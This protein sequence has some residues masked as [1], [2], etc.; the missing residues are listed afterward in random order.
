MKKL[1]ALAILSSVGL[2]ATAA[3]AEGLYVGADAQLQQ[4]QVKSDGAKKKT[5]L[6]SL[7]G[8]VGYE[9]NEYFAV[10]GRAG[11]GLKNGKYSLPNN[12]DMKV[13]EKYNLG[14]YALASYPVT[15]T[16]S[17]YAMGGYSYAKN[18][19]KVANQTEKANIKGLSYGI[20]AKYKLTSELALTTEVGHYG[21]YKKDGDKVSKNAVSLGV[22]Y[23]F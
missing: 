3:H 1:L 11:M 18:E 7:N 2:G 20:G 5:K 10:E 19:L 6:G 12:M 4:Q 23:S 14:A 17:V 16:F 13:K 22:Q 9:F 15:D 21:K 8:K